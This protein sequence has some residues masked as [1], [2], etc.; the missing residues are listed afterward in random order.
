[1]RKLLHPPLWVILLLIGVSAAGL[2][3]VFSAGY[4][5]SPAAYAVYALS[6]YTLTISVLFGITDL[7]DQLRRIRQGFLNTGFG[8]RF[9]ADEP[10]RRRVLQHC[11][12][13][14]NIVFAAMHLILWAIN[15]SWWFVVLA[16]YY[17][18]LSILWFLL[19]GYARKQTPDIRAEWKRT[20]SCAWLLL[21]I[22]LTL[23]GTVLMI[24]YQNRGFV[25]HGVL[26]YAMA[27]FTFYTVI[28]AMISLARSRKQGSPVQLCA[29][30]VSLSSALVSL[31]NLETAMLTEFGTD[32]THRT[33]RLFIILT[34]GGVSIVIVAMSALLI[35]HAHRN[36]SKKH[37]RR[38]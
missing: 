7:P 30:V 9:T 1:M 25:Y 20:R 31:L 35:L 6:A 34:G 28:N 29:A 26:I 24:L 23:S 3:L 17:T 11:S 37:K 10:F 8:A 4:E 13:G 38:S 15:R 32:M 36:L 27:A 21:A 5:Q 22:N 14:L 18:I 33:K 19:A 12:L 16:V 2:F